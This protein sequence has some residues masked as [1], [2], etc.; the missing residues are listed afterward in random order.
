MRPTGP[1]HGLMPGP[2]G[3]VPGDLSGGVYGQKVAHGKPLA[4]AAIAA[5]HVFGSTI[6]AS[7]ASALIAP[8]R[9]STSSGA[10]VANTSKATRRASRPSAAIQ[11][12][13][14]IDSMSSSTGAV[15]KPS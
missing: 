5:P 6:T 12:V 2:N 7:G 15:S 3:G 9:S 1:G 10:R 11:S 8:P 14:S 13:I 4:S